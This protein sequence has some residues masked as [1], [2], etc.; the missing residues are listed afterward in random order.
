[1]AQ[2]TDKYDQLTSRLSGLLSEM[3][4]LVDETRVE[5]VTKLRSVHVDLETVETQIKTNCVNHVG[6]FDEFKNQM[7]QKNATITGQLDTC[8]DV[9][10]QIK[11]GEAEMVRVSAENEEKLVASLNEMNENFEAQKSAL[12]EKVNNTFGQVENTCETT[13]IDI[14]G[15]LN[16]IINDVSSEQERI[17][18]HQFEY[19]DIMNTLLSTQKEFHEMLSSEIDGC[20]TRLNKFQHDELRMYTPTGQTP[21]K[22][23]YQYPKRLAATSPHSKII[24]DFWRTHNPSELECSAI[25]SE[26]SN[27]A[28]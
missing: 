7:L 6:A 23:E 20:H 2:S 11:S 27:L 26:V 4:T 13:R 8:L 3:K 17:E 19:D 1:M 14:D 25:I 21:A 12:I 18:S 15:G 24:D 28:L 9:A 5:S 16:G 22:R 10:K